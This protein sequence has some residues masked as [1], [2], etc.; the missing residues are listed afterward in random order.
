MFFFS[1]KQTQFNSNSRTK[2]HLN[3][4]IITITKLILVSL[5]KLSFIHTPKSRLCFFSIR[6]P[7][8]FI[9]VE[10]LYSSFLVICEQFVDSTAANLLNSSFSAEN[11]SRIVAI[12]HKYS[13]SAVRSL[14]LS[15]SFAFSRLSLCSCITFMCFGF[16]R[17]I[18]LLRA[19]KLI[20]V[21]PASVEKLK[22]WKRARAQA[23]H[24][25]LCLSAGDY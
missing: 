25:E 9:V 16:L 6:K 13:Y 5:Q 1:D 10:L 18:L 17:A 20:Y 11:W 19:L 4:A 12:N 2:F 23:F 8:I 21:A 22:L 3:H 15:L 24:A 14:Y 7:G